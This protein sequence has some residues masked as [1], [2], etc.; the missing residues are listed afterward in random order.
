MKLL[1]RSYLIVAVG[2]LVIAALA[3]APINR[4]KNASTKPSKATQTKRMHR[5]QPI[6][7]NKVSK[8]VPVGTV[9]LELN[10]INSHYPYFYE[11][12]DEATTFE[13]TADF[14]EVQLSEAN[15]GAMQPSRGTMYVLSR[16]NAGDDWYVHDC[17]V[18]LELRD[19]MPTTW[20]LH[21][22]DLFHSN[23][24]GADVTVK[25]VMVRDDLT[26]GQIV[27]DDELRSSLIASTGP[28]K[29][30]Y[31][32]PREP[33]A[34]ITAI[35]Q[36]QVLDGALTPSGRIAI[37]QTDEEFI[38]VDSQ[39]VAIVQPVDSDKRWISDLQPPGG[40]NYRRLS[41]VFGRK[42]KDNFHSYWVTLG[43]FPR[44]VLEKYRSIN[45]NLDSGADD[46]GI[47]A[48]DWSKY[49]APYQLISSQNVVTV[50]RLEGSAATELTIGAPE[51]QANGLGSLSNPLPVD[52]RFTVAGEIRFGED[53]TNDELKTYR[54]RVFIY[55]AQDWGAGGEGALPMAPTAPAYVDVKFS[56][57]YWSQSWVPLPK[58]TT[59]AEYIL[60]AVL[61]TKD[62]KPPLGPFAEEALAMSTPLDVEVSQ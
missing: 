18:F 8:G 51:Y 11:S 56:S 39:V 5:Q 29:L 44:R 60:V 48:R 24:F 45:G 46:A 33:I 25:C 37:L 57:G 34:L 40:G 41:V 62:H 42:E 55:R 12:A 6:A 7:T 53:L 30:V 3:S 10:A 47:T 31:E 59:N 22:A 28:F 4:Q 17:P 2:L 32:E 15:Q 20:R 49:F 16:D 27:S 9:T 1:S 19:G 61:W 43:V 54:V 35:N 58:A 26:P 21:I 13:G 23:E 52:R 14:A 38:P 50:Q 36:K